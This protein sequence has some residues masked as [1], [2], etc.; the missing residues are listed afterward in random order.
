MRAGDPDLA[1]EHLEMARR[2]DPVGPDHV[3]YLSMLGMARLYQGRFA[4]A[5][6]LEKEVTQQNHAGLPYAVLAASEA[7][8]GHAEA[9]RAAL[10]RY[11]NLTN[12]PI[13]DYVR[14]YSRDPAQRKTFLDGI[15]LAEGK[16]PAGDET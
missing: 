7:H 2:L 3:A 13:E 8:L 1:V 16:T 4:E 12:V 5:V 10:A 15:A 11:R 9:A 14:G 6:A